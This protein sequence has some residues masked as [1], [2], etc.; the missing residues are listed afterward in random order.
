MTTATTKQAREFRGTHT[1]GRTSEEL[2]ELV[3]HVGAELVDRAAGELD[4][5]SFSGEVGE[6]ITAT[7]KSA[8]ETPEET[9]V[10]TLV[11]GEG[12][13]VAVGDTVST[14][15]WVANGAAQEQVFSDYD[16]GAPESIPNEPDQLDAVFGALLEGQTY[17][18]RVAAVTSASEA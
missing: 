13:A 11:V 4:E 6:S 2:R 1:D 15:L 8:I 5:V 14:Y 16:N 3:S 17:G 9:V 7:W 18:S 10:T 12:D